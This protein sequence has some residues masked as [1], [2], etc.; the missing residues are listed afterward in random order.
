MVNKFPENFIFGTATSSFQIEMGSSAASRSTR[1]DWYQWVHNQDII[2][3]HLVSGD[4]PENGDD[5]WDT[6]EADFERAKELGTTAIR[7]SL[8]WA[9]LFPDDTSSVNSIV[10]KTDKGDVLDS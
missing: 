7:M 5:F 8:D 3:N 1:S 4:L 6:Y 9:R 2:S 10:K